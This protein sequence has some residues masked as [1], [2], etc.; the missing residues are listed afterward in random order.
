MTAFPAD[1]IAAVTHPDPYPYYAALAEHKPLYHD[2]TLGLWVASSAEAVTAVL[3]SDLCRVRPPTEPVPVA[4]RRSPAGD[5]FRHMVRFNDGESHCP[6]KEAVSAALGAITVTGAAERSAAC[7]LSLSDEIA[8]TRD[9]G[10]LSRFAFHLPIYV[11]ASLLGIP[12]DLLPQVAVWAGDFA[13]CLAPGSG[14]A[15]IARGTVAAGNLLAMFDA[16]APTLRD[17]SANTLL[18]LLAREARRVGRDDADVIVANG[19]GFLFQAYDATAGLIGNV[20]LAL[21]SHPDVHARLVADRGLLPQM[22]EE[23]LRYDPPVQN[24]RRFVADD[25]EIAGQAMHE[26]EEILV[27]LAAAGRDPSANPR[28]E[29]FDI[30]REDPRI[31]TFGAGVH[32]CPG[33]SLATTIARAGIA[34]LLASGADPERLAKPVTYRPSQNVRIALA[35][36]EGTY[37]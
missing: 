28:P 17:E 22:I 35:P 32:T 16:L 34:Q 10:H 11:A 18:A 30:F 24:T 19:I 5:I 25:G 37:A 12:D 2:M 27:I 3:T 4:L 23:V 20:L 6:F 7:A 9:P 29:R 14:P 15:Q 33:A 31:S 13:H 8:P 26:G 21:A 36:M 1:P